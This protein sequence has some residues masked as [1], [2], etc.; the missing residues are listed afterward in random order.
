VEDMGY[1]EEYAP[2]DYNIAFD[3]SRFSKRVIG[4]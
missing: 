1:G 4:E 3:P 2:S